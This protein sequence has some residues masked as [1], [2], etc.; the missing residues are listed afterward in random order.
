MRNVRERASDMFFNGWDSLLRIVVVGTLAYAG[1]VLILRVSGKR[2]LSKMN[3]FDFIVTIAFGS[4][5]ATLLLS[6]EVPLADG[7]VALGLLAGLQFV[8]TWISMRS[9]R[10]KR[11]ITAEP[12]L[13]AFDG[14]VLH[15]AMRAE[16][17]API[18]I[19]AA[20]REAGLPGL[21]AAYA[22]VLETQ[23]VLTVIPRS[24][25]RGSYEAL[26]HVRGGPEA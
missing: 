26:R 15:D 4:I 14:R 12:R 18:E 9:D 23:G 25:D 3:A 1:V 11:F 19:D 21:E 5:L 16:R 13:L 10:F 24:A 2:V 6:S 20:I 8:V 22:V 17:I 7:L